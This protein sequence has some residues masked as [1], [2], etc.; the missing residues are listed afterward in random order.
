DQISRTARQL[1]ASFGLAAQAVAHPKLPAGFD[2]LLVVTPEHC[3]T[4]AAD[5]WTKADLRARIREVTTH[6]L[7]WWRRDDE[8]GE[9]IPVGAINAD[10]ST[11]FPKFLHDG[12]LPIV[13]AGSTAGMFSAIVGGW[14]S[15]P[16]G[17]QMVTRRIN[18]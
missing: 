11:M 6:P 16:T 4:F 7:A 17:S 12:Q 1:G 3:R 5:G 14:V 18:P 15:G 10:D 9:G 13:V 2:A 8:C